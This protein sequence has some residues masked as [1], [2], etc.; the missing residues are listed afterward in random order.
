MEVL[1]AANFWPIEM[2]GQEYSRFVVPDMKIYHWNSRCNED[3]LGNS[4]KTDK[5][6]RHGCVR[7]ALCEHLTSPSQVIISPVVGSVVS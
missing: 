2:A 6:S 5:K 4:Q 1:F 7:W 3:L